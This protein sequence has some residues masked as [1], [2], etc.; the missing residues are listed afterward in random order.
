MSERASVDGHCASPFVAVRDAFARNFERHG[1]LGASVCVVRDGERVVDL[2]GGYRDEARR[3]RFDADT[4]VNV[5]SIT[6]GIVSIVIARL[7]E[8][9][10]LDPA[11]AVADYWP[12]FAAAGKQQISVSQLLS[13]QAGLPALRATLPPDAQIDWM[14]MCEALA[15]E[16]PW[17]APGRRAG[18]HAHTWG[19]LAGE[20]IRRIDGRTPGVFLRE[21]WTALLGLDV[22]LGFGPE[23][24]ARVAPI[25]AH[26]PGLAP[27]EI[28]YWLRTPLRMPMRLRMLTNPAMPRAGLDTRAW[29]AAEI[30]AVNAHASARGLAGLYEAVVRSERPIL[31]R[32]T[33]SRVTREQ[34]FAREIVFGHRMRFGLGSMLNAPELGIGP[35]PRAFGHTGAGGSVAFADP[36]A[37]LGFAYVMNRRHRMRT[38]LVDPAAALV[39]A[40]YQSI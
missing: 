31:A 17:W 38:L 4:L 14:R 27:R 11:R 13:H 1:E 2:S 34:V 8:T 15:A 12:E 30:P 39:R 33:V 7:V 20:L 40:V 23:L 6:K 32:E 22:H 5:F 21:E 29:R 19:W 36:D 3:V 25:A 9:G 37:R 35:S 16:R 10:R 18:Y 26:D 28:L 24:D